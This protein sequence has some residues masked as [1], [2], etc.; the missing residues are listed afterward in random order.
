MSGKR[1]G[2]AR[3]STAEQNPDRQ[4]EGIVLDK[5][6]IDYCSGK[7]TNRPQLKIMLDYLREDDELFVHSLD[8]LARNMK[9]LRQLVD[10][11][12]ARSIKIHFITE[13]LVFTGE[14]SPMA[15]LT[16]QIFGSVAE[17]LR[18]VNLETQ[19]EGIR[20]AKARGVYEGRK[21]IFCN[22]LEEKI[23]MEMLTRDKKS[24]IAK[25]LGISR[26]SL[27][28]FLK[29]IEEKDKITWSCVPQVA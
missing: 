19:A 24:D 23:R 21:S 12:T 5:K 28:R 26:T 16:L 6:F 17:F 11:L 25:N 10:D 8:R 7:D 2:Y 29:I 15:M 18:K 4:L 27:Y 9:D 20:L 22:E 13:G 14:D 3:V 1:I